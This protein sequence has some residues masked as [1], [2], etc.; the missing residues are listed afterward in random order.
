MQL[1]KTPYPEFYRTFMAAGFFPNSNKITRFEESENY[2]MFKTGLRIY[3]VKKKETVQSSVPLEEIFCNEIAG[4]IRQCSPALDAQLFTIKENTHAFQI[5]WS[6]GMSGN[7]LYYGISMVQ[8]SEKGFLSNIIE[9]NKVNDS[10]LEQICSHLVAFHHQ[11]EVSKSKDDGSPDL[12]K[13]KLDNF[14]YQAKKFL[15]ITINKAV[16]DMTLRPLDKYLA[17]NRKVFLRR[18]K[19]ECIRKIQGCFIPRKIH[20]S[21]EG[22]NVLGK[23]SDPLKN[24]YNDVASDVADLTVELRLSNLDNMAKIFIEKYC[25]LSGDREVKQ[26]LP[27]YQALRCLHLGLKYSIQ[28]NQQE[29]LQAEN[30]RQLAVKYYEQTIDVVRGL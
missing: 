13:S 2:W 9:K 12:I 24:R 1:K 3:K 7:P 8:L 4:Q 27:V 21:K 19:R 23:T 18:I 22:V 29:N 5:D 17:D 20:A 16:I 28:A 11:S 15:G 30:L 6:N 10:I 25:H 14:Y 26:I